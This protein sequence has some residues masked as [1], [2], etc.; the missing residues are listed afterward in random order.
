MLPIRKGR[1]FPN[2]AVLGFLVH[3]SMAVHALD[4]WVVLRAS[5]TDVTSRKS[6]GRGVRS[7]MGSSVLQYGLL[8]T[9]SIMEGEKRKY[10]V[11]LWRY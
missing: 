1:G 7:G 2:L 3:R 4:T 10:P 5:P 9:H 11:Q 6:Y 8:E